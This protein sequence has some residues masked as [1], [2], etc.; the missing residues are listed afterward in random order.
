MNNVLNLASSQAMSI[1]QSTGFARARVGL[2]IP[3]SN[4]LSEPQFRTY[5]PVDVGIHTTRLQMTGPHTK[6]LDV[7]AREV[8]RA[9]SGLADAKCDVIVFHCTGNSMEHGPEGEKSLLEAIRSQSNAAAITTAQAVLAALE[10]SSISRLVLVSPYEQAINDH[11]IEYLEHFGIETLHNVA[12][13]VPVSDGF[14]SVPPS[15]WIDVVKDNVRPEA[16]GYFLSCTNTTQIDV[17]ERLEQFLGKPVI[18]SNQATIWACLKYLQG[19]FGDFATV[20]GL[21]SL[22][23]CSANEALLWDALGHAN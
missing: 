22:M 3:S 2:I 1:E 13:D 17:I 14:L 6:P 20:R 21:G 12:L 5:M 18:N 15:R 11:E 16:D 9:A 4:R 23:N 8:E 10:A 19:K 7:L